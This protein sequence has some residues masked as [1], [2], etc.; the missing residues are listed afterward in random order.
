[1]A[2]TSVHSICYSAAAPADT[3][4]NCASVLECLSPANAPLGGAAVGDRILAITTS[5]ALKS[6]AI[7]QRRSSLGLA[8]PGFTLL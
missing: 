5:G 2:N 7:E 4:G 3:V 6:I 8:L 1:M